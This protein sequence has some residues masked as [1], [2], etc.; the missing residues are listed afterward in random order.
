MVIYRVQSC[1]LYRPR[2]HGTFENDRSPFCAPEWRDPVLLCVVLA[3]GTYPPGP[4]DIKGDCGGGRLPNTRAGLIR[5]V[6]RILICTV[7]RYALLCLFCFISGSICAEAGAESMKMI[8]M[9]P[10]AVWYACSNFGN[11]G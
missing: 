9:I 5:R 7:P 1:T 11:V 2:F 8:P 3:L 4:V 6:Y 10:D